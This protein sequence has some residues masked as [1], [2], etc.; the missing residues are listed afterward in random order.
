VALLTGDGQQID[1]GLIWRVFQSSGPAGKSKLIAE[2]REASPFIRLRPGEYTVNAAFGR[3]NLTRK[4]V[5]KPDGPPFEPFV[6]NAGALPTHILAPGKYL[7]TAAS[8]GHLLKNTF[9]I[10]D[11]D[12]VNVEV[13]MATPDDQA[14]GPGM[15]EVAPRAPAPSQVMPS[16]DFKNP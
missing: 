10:K 5:V 15:T 11:G 7:V 3:A 1:Q 9:E 12:V 6:L 4:I 2:L 16:V 13:L 8:G 14:P